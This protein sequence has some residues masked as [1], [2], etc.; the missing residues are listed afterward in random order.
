M[1]VTSKRMR[2]AAHLTAAF[3]VIGVTGA[4]SQAIAQEDDNPYA[5]CLSHCDDLTGDVR[6]ACRAEC[7]GDPW[8]VP[9][10]NPGGGDEKPH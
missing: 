2:F 3:F 9:P 1:K 8:P 6:A 7:F 5:H 10:G 4:S